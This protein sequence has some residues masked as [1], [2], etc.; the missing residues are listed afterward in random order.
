MLKIK[1][2][3]ALKAKAVELKRKK[4]RAQGALSHLKRQLMEEFGVKSISSASTKLSSLRE[5]LETADHDYNVAVEEFE[6]KY[7]SLFKDD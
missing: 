2:Y 5:E 4:D 6:Q 7:G 3:K 1:Q